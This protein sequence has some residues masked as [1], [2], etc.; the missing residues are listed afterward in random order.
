MAGGWLCCQH[1]LPN[2]HGCLDCLAQL[3]LQAPQGRVID[4]LQV[5][6]PQAVDHDDPDLQQAITASLADY[7]GQAQAPRST[8]SQGGGGAGAGDG[9]GEVQGWAVPSGLAAVDL[10]AARLWPFDQIRAAT[11]GFKEEG[12]LGEGGFGRVYRGQL[13]GQPVAIKVQEAGNGPC[14]GGF[15]FL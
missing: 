12:L 7:R 8:V 3:C 15:V 5:N 13:D 9:G 14:Q 4:S 6:Q 10:A 1:R 2:A 11:G